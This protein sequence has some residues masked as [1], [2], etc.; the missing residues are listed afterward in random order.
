MQPRRACKD[1]V[2]LAWTSRDGQ[3]P[4]NQLISIDQG[5][6]A[7]AAVALRLHACLNSP[8]AA[9]RSCLA[10]LSGQ[11]ADKVCAEFIDRLLVRELEFQAHPRAGMTDLHINAEPLG[12][13]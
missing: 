9:G 10:A 8:K 1:A 3:R 4:A 13:P 5:D 6:K 2:M 12:Q 11:H 7:I